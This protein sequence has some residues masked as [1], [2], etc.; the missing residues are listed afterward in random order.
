MLTSSDQDL[1]L[2]PAS[3][4]TF[5]RTLLLRKILLV[6]LGSRRHSA[7]MLDKLVRCFVA[8]AVLYCSASG[9]SG[10]LSTQRRRLCASAR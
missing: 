2:H 8:T 9:C 1:V 10:F 3:S 7:I 5:S 6:H 4:L